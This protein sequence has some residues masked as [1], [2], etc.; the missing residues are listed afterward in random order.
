MNKIVGAKGPHAFYQGF[1]LLDV[2]ISLFLSTLILTLLTQF[3]L[4][5]KRQYLIAQD[6]LA[7]Q[8]DV[9]WVSDLLSDNI[10]RA[11]FTPCL[12]VD[13]LAIT[14]RR[15][16]SRVLNGMIISP[17]P[18]QAI[19][20]NRMSEI[21]SNVL[22]IQNPTQLRVS[23]TALIDEKHPVMI[24]DC[25]HAE[26]HQIAL[27]EPQANSTL[28][29]LAEPLHY[30]YRDQAYMGEW[31]EEKWFIKK[32]TRGVKALYYRAIQTEEITPLIHSLHIKEDRRLLDVVLG[33]DQ[34]K[35]H[36]FSVVI[37]GTG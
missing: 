30:H 2:L 35:T 9:Q 28:I 34:E 6:R 16:P 26:V 33:L 21:F 32:N 11:G 13:Q 8:F 36:A 1:G 20:I 31:L 15:N 19:Q 24:A 37:R 17:P 5:N 12:G 3:Y 14:D 23:S 18:E 27:Y 22:A 4:G 25:N 10:R 7:S 29:T